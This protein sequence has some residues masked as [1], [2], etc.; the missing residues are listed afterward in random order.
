MKDLLY[1]VL[2]ILSVAG[3]GYFFWSYTSQKPGDVSWLPFILFV[4]FA[5]LAV[6]FGAMFLLGKVNKKE[7]IHITE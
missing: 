3:A 4:I 6:A 7:E 1:V 5:I 2:G